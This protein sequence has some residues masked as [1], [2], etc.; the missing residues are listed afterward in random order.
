M[1][2]KKLERECR[3][4][5]AGFDVPQPF[6]LDTFVADIAARRGRPMHLH[7]LPAPHTE[8]AP[9]G[10]WLAT[11]QADH[12]FYAAGTGRIHQQHIILH[13][14]GHVLCDHVAPGLEPDDAT[15]LLLP[16]LDP[17]TVARVLHRSSYTAPQEQIAEMIATM[18]NER[19]LND[20]VRRPDDPLL[21]RLHEALAE[22]ARRTERR[23]PR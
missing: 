7:P 19:A 1:R 9:C 13:E 21:G 3:R 5:L 10:V 23:G 17:A 6:D 15:A 11:E 12:V 2:L 22:D 8:G 14:I 16:D 18:I 4:L 20:Y